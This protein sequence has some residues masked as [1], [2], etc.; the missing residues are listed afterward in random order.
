M[1]ILFTPH[2]IGNVEIKNRFVR[3]ATYEGMADQ[4][5]KVTDELLSVYRR[6]AQGDIGL[7]LSSF[8]FVHPL[9]RALH[10]QLGIHNDGAIP[11]LSR[12]ADVVHEGG[13]K[14][15]FEIIH[16]GRQTRPELIGQR[17]LGPSAIRRDPTSFIKPAAMTIHDI[18]EVITAFIAAARR[19]VAAGGDIVYLHAGGGDLLNQFLSPFFNCRTDEW[20]GSAI[21]RFRVVREII[22][23]VKASL[24]DI[25]ILV[26]MNAQDFTPKPGVTPELAR[27]YAAMLAEIGIDALELTSGIKSY[28]LM[29]CWRGE[30][31]IQELLQ[32]LPVWMR[33]LGRIKLKSWSGKY[34]LIEG[35]NLD[36]LKTV[37]PVTVA[38]A[39]FLVGGMRRFEHMEQ[40]ITKGEADFI[41]LCRPFIRQPDLVKRF[42]EGAKESTCQSCNRCIGAVA[43][44]IPTRCYFNGLPD[45]K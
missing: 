37:K 44:H 33:P 32:S 21:N 23:G 2:K 3:A 16:S 34:N 28:S 39:L 31:P 17:P 7:I 36:Y 14:I 5:G 9:G 42:R 1:S 26:K 20:G 45:K 30:V 27:E 19:S 41:C 43:N 29:R 6:L 12:L 40:V 15:A 4:T 35:W 8:M 38:M 18:R 10:N 24:G 11:G 22:E 13:G 25:P